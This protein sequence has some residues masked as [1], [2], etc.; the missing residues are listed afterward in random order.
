[1]DSDHAL[2]LLQAALPVRVDRLMPWWVT[3][4]PR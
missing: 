1:M 2:H 4:G 3:V